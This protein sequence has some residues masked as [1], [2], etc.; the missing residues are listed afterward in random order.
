MR[1]LTNSCPICSWK[2]PYLPSFLIL[3]YSY[4]LEG[5]GEN[6]ALKM[7]SLPRRLSLDA[8]FFREAEEAFGLSCLKLRRQDDD[9]GD[10]DDG[11]AAEATAEASAR[12][13]R[14]FLSRGFSSALLPPLPRLLHPS[15][16]RQRT[17]Q[18][19]GKARGEGTFIG[20][21]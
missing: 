10:D 20:E 13:K 6:E 4:I 15:G 2:I 17:Q 21:R 12:T 16:L 14:P 1:L 8:V 19:R 5:Q 3:H 9:D 7:P 11:A 18:V